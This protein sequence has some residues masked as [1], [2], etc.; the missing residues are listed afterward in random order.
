LQP[1]E[2]RIEF[3]NWTV[4]LP[5]WEAPG[6]PIFISAKDVQ[7]HLGVEHSIIQ[8]SEWFA[9]DAIPADMIFKVTTFHWRNQGPR[10]PHLMSRQI[11][12]LG[13]DVMERSQAVEREVW[14]FNVF[15]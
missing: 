15:P 12:A 13:A 1:S 11:Q 6:G 14:Q 10:S 8:A 2:L 3:A 7:A 4:L 9:L 5:V